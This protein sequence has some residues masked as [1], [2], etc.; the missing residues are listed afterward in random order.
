M[1]DRPGIGCLS[2]VTMDKSSDVSESQFPYQQ[3]GFL[4]GLYNL[5]S[6]LRH[7]SNDEK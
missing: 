5:M 6:V 3:N 1:S 7:G 4:R 2:C